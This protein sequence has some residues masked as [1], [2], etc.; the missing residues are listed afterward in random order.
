[1]A[2]RIQLIPMTLSHL[3][4]RSYFKPFKYYFVPR[5]AM[6]AWYFLTSYVRPSVHHKSAFYQDG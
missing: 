6:L 5:D 3:Q 2:Y 1:M 4:G